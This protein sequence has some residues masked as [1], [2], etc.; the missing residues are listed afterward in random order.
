MSVPSPAPLGSMVS[1]TRFTLSDTA[2][3]ESP[4][5][6]PGLPGR[7]GRRA[8]APTFPSAARLALALGQWPRSAQSYPQTLRVAGAPPR[9][10]Y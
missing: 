3:H 10:L 6:W 4:P 2:A 5:E 1:P 8:R 9:I 7:G